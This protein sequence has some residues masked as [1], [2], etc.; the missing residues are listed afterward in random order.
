MRVAVLPAIEPNGSRYT[1]AR[2]SAG[3]FN[4]LTCSS[5]G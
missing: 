1:F 4:F 3:I 5:L 2:A